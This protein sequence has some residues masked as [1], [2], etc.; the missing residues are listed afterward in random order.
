MQ[1]EL[2]L[3]ESKANICAVCPITQGAH[4]LAGVS[5]LK[6]EEEEG[7][8]EEEEEGGGDEEEEE[9]DEKEEEE[10]EEFG[11]ILLNTSVIDHYNVTSSTIELKR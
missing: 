6:E 10:E 1:L 11:V 7:G 2:S 8:D 3:A 5:I 4:V 9:D